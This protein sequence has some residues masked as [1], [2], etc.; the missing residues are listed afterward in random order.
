VGAAPDEEDVVGDGVPGVVDADEE[1]EQG[2]GGDAAE[3]L[4]GV[5][6]TE[7]GGEDQI[8]VS[9]EG[10]RGVEEPVFELR[11]IG[12]LGAH[13]SNND[14]GIDQT[15]EADQTPGVGSGVDGIPRSVEDGGE[16]QN[17][18]EMDDGGGGKGA[19]GESATFADGHVGDEGDDDELQADQRAGGRADNDIEVGPGRGR[20]HV[21]WD[22]RIEN[23]KG[24]MEIREGRRE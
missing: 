6:T 23:R 18:G 14:E 5:R 10:K 13:A 1:Q 3:G 16:K 20:G 22:F 11:T 19:A 4:R 24:K 7:V 21:P 9:E 15:G 2:G 12:I 8:G 17:D